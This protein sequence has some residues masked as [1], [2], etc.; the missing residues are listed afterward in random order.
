VVLWKDLADNADIDRSTPI[1]MDGVSGVTMRTHL[2]LLLQ[3]V[4]GGG[5]RLGHI[6]NHNVIVIG[7]QHNL[8]RKQVARVYDIRDLVQSPS[9]GFSMFAGGMMMPFPM[10]SPPMMPSTVNG[11][12]ANRQ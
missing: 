1:G 8:P 3:A 9:L 12:T 2:E 5:P 6:V 10:V 4:A 7:T 11:P